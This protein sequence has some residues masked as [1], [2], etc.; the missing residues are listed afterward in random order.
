M[1]IRYQKDIVV[2]E[3]FGKLWGVNLIAAHPNPMVI[4]GHITREKPADQDQNAEYD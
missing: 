3:G 4:I 1:K 2:L